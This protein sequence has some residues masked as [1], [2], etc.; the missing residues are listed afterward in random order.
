MPD[1]TP[2]VFIVDPDA[3]SRE[4]VEEQILCAGLR[5]QCFGTAAEFLHRPR[6]A[7]PS[8]LVLDV[9]LPDLGGLELQARVT[10]ESNEMPIIFFTVCQDVATTVRAMK[11]GAFE[12]LTKPS[13]MHRLSSVVHNAVE[14]SRMTLACEAEVHTLR[15]RLWSLTPRERQVL[16]LVASGRMNKQVGGDLGISEITVKAHRGKVMR[17]MQAASFAQLINM[18]ARLRLAVPLRRDTTVT[19]D[20]LAELV[21]STRVPT[22]SVLD[23]GRRR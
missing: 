2:V 8:C 12:F 6:L 16:T 4:S 14:R 7:V 21:V 20:V 10:A 18:A 22:A 23:A 15:E 1:V 13:D 11:A 5:P 3:S 9:S 19:E 17:K